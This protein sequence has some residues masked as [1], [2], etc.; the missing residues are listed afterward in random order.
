MPLVI[1]ITDNVTEIVAVLLCCVVEEA[2]RSGAVSVDCFDDFAM[3]DDHVCVSEMVECSGVRETDVRTLGT[4]VGPGTGDTD[5][6][7]SA[8]VSLGG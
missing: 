4:S 3:V 6:C 2:S 8:G 7:W 1:E 5:C